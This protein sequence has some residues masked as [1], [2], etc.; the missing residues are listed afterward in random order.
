MAETL[1]VVPLPIALVVRAFVEQL[2]DANQVTL[3]PTGVRLSDVKEVLVPFGL[4]LCIFG[5]L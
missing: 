2:F 3:T 1:E 4:L 5:F